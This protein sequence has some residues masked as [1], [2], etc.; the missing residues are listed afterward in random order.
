MSAGAK[1]GISNKVKFTAKRLA[2]F[3]CASGKNQSFLWDSDLQGL[4]LRVTATDSRAFIYEGKLAGKSL[5]VTIGNPK[6]WT[7]EKA[8]AEARRLRTL[9]D[10]GLD[11]RVEKASAIAKASAVR[12]GLR[13]ERC[14]LLR[15]NQVDNKTT[16]I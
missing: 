13:I 12:E 7:I 4:G 5:R 10:Q 8:Q 1:A 2:D 9:V 16:I 15:R 14:H 11:P 3:R 6:T